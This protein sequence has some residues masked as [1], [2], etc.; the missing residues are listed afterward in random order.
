MSKY[1]FKNIPRPNP[2]TPFSSSKFPKTIISQNHNYSSFIEKSKIKKIF[3][4][5]NNNLQ[6]YQSIQSG[7]DTLLMME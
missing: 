7:I 1:D 4:N 5:K 2:K 6:N 3:S